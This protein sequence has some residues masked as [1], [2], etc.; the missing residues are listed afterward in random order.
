MARRNIMAVTLVTVLLNGPAASAEGEALSADQQAA[1]DAC[2]EQNM[3]MAMAW[4]MIE[5]QC[6]ESAM[7]AGAKSD[8]ARFE[9]YSWSDDYVEFRDLVLA[10]EAKAAA[11]LGDQFIDAA[12]MDLNFHNP[13]FGVVAMEVGAA[14]QRAGQF[15]RARALY[16][17]AAA[18]FTFARGFADPDAVDAIGMLADVALQMG[19]V[20][21]AVLLYQEAI[22]RAAL[23]GLEDREDMLFRGLADAYDRTDPRI[24]EAIRDALPQD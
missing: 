15:D 22:A 9:G 14:H 5:A 8:A 13:D 16:G 19:D 24:S 18:A 7:K 4:E 6:L 2:L 20:D 23:A 11:D 1:Y 17:Q 10:G 21:G 12:S 3:A